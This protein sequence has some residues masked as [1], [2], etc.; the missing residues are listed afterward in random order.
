VICFRDIMCGVYALMLQPQHKNWGAANPL[1]STVKTVHK[2]MQ[3][4]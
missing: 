1:T 3:E 4:T 2:F